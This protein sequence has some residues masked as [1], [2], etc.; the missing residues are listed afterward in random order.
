MEIIIKGDFTVKG[1]KSLDA[2]QQP[3]KYLKLDITLTPSIIPV[4]AESKK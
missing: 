1:I 2:V 4:I 3:L